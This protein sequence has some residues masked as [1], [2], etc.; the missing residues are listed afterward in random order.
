MNIQLKPTKKKPKNA[1]GSNISSGKVSK[2][3]DK[4]SPSLVPIQESKDWT[5]QLLEKRKKLSYG[6]TTISSDKQSNRNNGDEEEDLPI[7]VNDTQA[8][9]QDYSDCP[10]APDS[11]SYDKMPVSQFGESMLRAMGWKG[12]AEPESESTSDEQTQQQRPA[13]LGLGAKYEPGLQDGNLH[14][15]YVPLKKKLRSSDSASS[16]KHDEEEKSRA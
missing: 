8:F 16:L 10:D 7:V 13:L 15:P 9:R 3:V 6:L 5:L 11:A 1:F 4:P 12:D 2:S 14:K